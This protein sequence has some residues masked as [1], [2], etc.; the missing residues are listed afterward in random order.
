MTPTK[1]KK[2]EKWEKLVDEDFKL[3]ESQIDKGIFCGID[4]IGGLKMSIKNLIGTLIQQERDSFDKVLDDLRTEVWKLEG[5]DITELLQAIS[6]AQK[7]I[8]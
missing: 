3:I 6:T 2:T 4:L 1:T 5:V 8:K 7:R